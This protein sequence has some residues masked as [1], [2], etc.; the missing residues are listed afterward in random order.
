MAVHAVACCSRKAFEG[1]A[2]F[3]VFEGEDGGGEEGGVFGAVDGDAGDGDARGHLGDG[4]EGVEPGGGVSAGGEGDTDHRQ[5]GHRGDDAGE[6]SSHA[7][8]GD[9]DLE[10]AAGGCSGELLDSGGGAVGGHDVELVFDA[11]VGEGLDAGFEE[12][13]SDFEPVRTATR[14][15]RGGPGWS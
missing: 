4:E 2:D 14:G 1:L 3:G 7:G 8:G 12:G 11:E 15:I 5:R 13:R 6:V 10:A 9:D